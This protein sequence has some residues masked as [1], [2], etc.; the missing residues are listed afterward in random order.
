MSSA[1]AP[2]RR[3]TTKGDGLPHKV[4][5]I[6]SRR[7]AC[8]ATGLRSAQ[9]DAVP[10]ATQIRAFAVVVGL[11][12]RALKSPFRKAGRRV[13][14]A[15]NF[16]RP[17]FRQ[18]Q[19]LP[20]VCALG[21]CL[22]LRLQPPPENPSSAP[23]LTINSWA[24][25]QGTLATHIPEPRAGFVVLRRGRCARRYAQIQTDNDSPW[26]PAPWPYSR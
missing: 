1:S 19:Q 15:D 21:G 12:W 18:C 16:P 23:E 26:R 10:E 2:R 7:D 8:R 5:S 25:R 3:Q 24:F 6:A 4:N 11:Y 9:S 13:P 17:P 20:F 22:P 14:T